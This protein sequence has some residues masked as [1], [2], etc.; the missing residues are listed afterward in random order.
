METITLNDGTVIENAYVVKLDES[1]IVVYCT[2]VSLED[3]TRLFG[4][5]AKTEWMESDQYGDKQIW[6]GFTELYA[7]QEHLSGQ[8]SA[9]LRIPA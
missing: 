8:R 3:M 7:V 9:G 1:M 2:G 6:R 4:N 5:P